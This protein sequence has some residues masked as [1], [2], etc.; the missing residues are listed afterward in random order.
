MLNL[1]VFSKFITDPDDAHPE[2]LQAWMGY[3]NLF[4][5]GG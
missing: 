5:A 3:I 4:A 2:D 1:D